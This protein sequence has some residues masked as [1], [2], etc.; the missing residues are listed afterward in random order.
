MSANETYRKTFLGLLVVAVTI[1]FLA[2]MRGFLV[3]LLLAAIFSAI[4]HPAYRRVRH[5]LRGRKSLASAVT[6]LLTVLVVIVPLIVFVGA[7]V[8]QAVQVSQSAV[9]WIQEQLENPSELMRRLEAVPGFDRLAPY[10]QQI[11]TKIGELVGTI[12]TFTVSKLSAAT[13]GTLALAVQLVILVYAMF[14]FLM[15][16]AAA[17]DRILVHVPLSKSESDVIVGRFVSVTRATLVSVLVIGILQ[18]TLG[19]LAFAVAGIPGAVFWGTL[20]AVLSMIPGVGATLVWLPAVVYLVLSGQ[21]ATGMLLFA[22]CALIV[23]SVDNLL[24]P[25]LVGRD[26]KLPQLVV[27]LST[28]GGITLM[29]VVGF[30]IGPVIAALFISVWDIY[31]ASVGGSTTPAKSQ[32]RAHR[33]DLR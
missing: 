11:M 16:G 23:G 31:T 17:L 33:K 12:G 19:G 24:R 20:M 10:R 27:L 3:T 5:V 7:L 18:G 1:G 21:V 25:R 4:L 30:I 6:L 32:A 26:T 13:K 22:F 2:V 9:P 8:T 29:G 14:F 15:D 28:L